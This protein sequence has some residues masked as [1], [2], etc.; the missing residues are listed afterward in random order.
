MCSIGFA[1]EEKSE[2]EPLQKKNVVKLNVTALA[3]RNI[4]LQYERQI[5]KRTSIAAQVRTIPYGKLPFQSTFENIEDNGDVPFDQFK[6]GSFGVTPELRFYLGKKGAL[7]GFYIGP[8][9]NYSNYKMDLP[10]SYTSGTTEKTGVFNGKLNT[11]TGGIQFGSQ[12]SLGKKIVLDW[13]IF[14][15]NYGTADGTLNFAAALTQ[16]EQDDL[17][18]ELEDVKNEAPFETIKS[19]N[20]DN[21]GASVEV[22]GPWGGMRGGFLLGFR[23]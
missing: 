19:Y 10:I 17:R 18:R 7:H 4:S 11:I 5:G 1:Q 22:K 9:I 12:F 20:V 16:L 2:A 6:F 14:G 8:F 21:N 15:P 23:F 13:W 3:F